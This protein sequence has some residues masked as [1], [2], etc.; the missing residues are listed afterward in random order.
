MMGRKKRSEAQS[1]HVIR[2]IDGL[3]LETNSSV[4]AIART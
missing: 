1:H 3:A 2:G 4:D